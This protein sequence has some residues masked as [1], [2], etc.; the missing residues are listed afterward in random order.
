MVVPSTT[1]AFVSPSSIVNCSGA[2][3]V[4]NDSI[5]PTRLNLPTLRISVSQP[6]T[7]NMDATSELTP[8]TGTSSSQKTIVIMSLS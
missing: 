4:R 5:T 3:P 1:D 8:S 2:T 6:S 7:Q